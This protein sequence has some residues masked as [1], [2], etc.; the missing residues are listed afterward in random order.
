MN[1]PTKL[2]QIASLTG[3]CLMLLL[4]G[5]SKD[6]ADSPTGSGDNTTF[7]EVIQSAGD[8][9][10]VIPEE[11]TLK[12]DTTIQ[13]VVGDEDYFCTRKT[14]S[15]TEAPGEFPL[16]DVNADLIFPGN[17]LQGATL[18]HAT[19]SPIPVK[20][21]PGTVVMIIDNGADSVSR[22]IPE[23][24]L[25]NVFNAKNQIIQDNPGILPAR[26]AF[27]MEQISSRE[28]L[29]L[30]LDVSYSN[31]SADVS[32]SLAFSSDK[33]YNRFLV[34]L[35][36]S[37][38]TIAYQLPTTKA[39]IFDQS[40]T[41]EQLGQ[42]VGPGNPPA[43]IGS[44]TYG[45]KFYLLIESTSSKE[46][47]DASIHAS[48]N[49]AVSQGQLDASATYIKDLQSVKVKA[50]ALGGEQG[51]AL[52][53][54]TT[55]FEALK[56]FLA[57]GGDIRTGVALS[58]V[59]RSLAHPDQI[60]KVK[61]ATEYDVV[62]CIPVGESVD[63]PIVWFRADQGVSRT[64]TANL[65]TKWQNFFS[66]PEFDALPPTK[67]YGG[68]WISGALTGPNLPAVKFLPGESSTNNEGVLGFSGVNFVGTDFTIWF[69]AK[70]GTQ[71]ANYPENVF[72]GSGTLAGQ[73]LTLGFRNATQLSV[74]NQSDTLNVSMLTPVDQYK[75]YTVRFSESGGYQVW[76]NGEIDP[77][78]SDPGM[79]DKLTSFLGT[80]LGSNNGN[81]VYLAEFKAYATA[82]TDLQRKSL[83]KALLIKYGL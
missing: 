11:D 24:N 65:V 16:F 67:A 82:V 18:D 49:A 4:P 53:A 61:V 80:R 10:P 21:G 20:R 12:V 55:D 41:P 25:S 5:C 14:V 26:F 15:A 70:L 8:F 51:S 69:V 36:Q 73:K 72:T 83:D 48:F 81:T 13:E 60:V 9:A 56:D 52:S 37:Y 33:E 46:D 17:L 63:N 75:L 44:V 42:Y 62:D 66:K 40:V 74:S 19:P 71:F 32:A 23:V 45:R 59:V 31:L 54:I 50:F 39:E 47:M 57:Q 77:T 35:D 76:V 1:I 6:S 7:D 28:Q 22:Y 30:A 58:Y 3:L 78:A 38:F 34:R 43:F 27:S 79:T 68:R 64:G 2:K 29:G